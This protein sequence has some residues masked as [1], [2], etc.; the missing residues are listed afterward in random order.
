MPHSKNH[1]LSLLAPPELE[2]LAPHLQSVDMPHGQVL[3]EQHQDVTRVY[4]PHNG[5]VSYVVAMSDGKMI[6]TGM[7]GRDGVVGGIQVL[8]GKV[9]PNRII[10]Q[11]PGAASSIDADTMRKAVDKSIPIRALLAKYEQ[12][13]IAQVQQ[14]TACNASH[15]VEARMCRW[16][17]R[18]HDLAGPD[19]PLTQEFLAQMMGVRRTSVSLVATQLQD[20]GLIRYRRGNVHVESVEKLRAATC[21]CHDA[22]NSHY[23]KIFGTTLPLIDQNSR[24]TSPRAGLGSPAL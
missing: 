18:M 11:V 2:L 1:F 8:D 21:E 7:V 4:F 23:A 24:S 13:F 20:K 16:L 6:E 12:F 22:V 9:S 5:V 14:S 10:V 17:L 3:A 19:L 15:T